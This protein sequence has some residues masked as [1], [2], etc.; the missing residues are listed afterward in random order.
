MPEI[1]LVLE[2]SKLCSHSVAV[3]N[4]SSG[5]QIVG[6]VISLS[7]CSLCSHSTLTGNC[8]PIQRFNLRFNAVPGQFNKIFKI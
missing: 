2:R 5:P 4:L 3:G 1:L 8:V 7:F 6:A